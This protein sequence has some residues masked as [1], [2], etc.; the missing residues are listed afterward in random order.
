MLVNEFARV[1]IEYDDSANGCRLRI[2]SLRTGRTAHLDPLQ[3]ES[4]TWLTDQE[5]AK[6]LSDPFGPAEE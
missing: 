6:L 3:L 4:L 2:Q 1:L 5:F